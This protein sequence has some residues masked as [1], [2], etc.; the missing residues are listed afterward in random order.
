MS[1]AWWSTRSE[2]SRGAAGP[3]RRPHA[4][5]APRASAALP[6]S[7]MVGAPRPVGR[8]PSP[9]APLRRRL[10]LSGMVRLDRFMANL[11]PERARSAAEAVERAPAALL[12]DRASIPTRPSAWP[13]ILIQQRGPDRP[14]R[15]A[16]S[17]A[18]ATRGFF[19]G[20]YRILRLARRGGGW[21]RST[22]R[23]TSKDGLRV[24]IK[25]LPPS[26]A[27][28][29]RPGPAPVPP[30][31]GPLQAGPP[32]QPRPD[33]STSAGPATSTSWCSST[34][35]ARASTSSSSTPEAGRSGSPTPPATSSRWSTAS[36]PPTTPA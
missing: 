14:T 28:D 30:R 4:A 35:R 12:E 36:R 7:S 13:R 34:S 23:P 2:P 6:G 15:P 25:V 10:R 22:S 24:A 19:L 31:D 8:R 9:A 29:R 1:P 16:R 20:D 11:K 32:P 26:K 21:A 33:A 18:G 27:A 5:R 17:S 3:P